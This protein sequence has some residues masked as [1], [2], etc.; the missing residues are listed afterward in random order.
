MKGKG[1]KDFDRI[2]ER[3]LPRVSDKEVESA[4][5]R[6]L[7]M[8]RQ[9]HELQEALDNFRTPGPATLSKYVSLGFVDQL[10]L[11]AVY[12]LRGNGSTLGVVEKVNQ[13]LTNKNFDA[14]A[15]FVSLD[16]LERGRLIA[17][18]IVDE[19]QDKK[20]RVVLKITPEGGRALREVR[21]GLK[22][23]LE[24]LKDIG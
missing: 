11:T 8:L 12:L 14:G 16:R 17:S 13:L 4:R 9:R 18:R 20:K 7:L 6:F 23:L 22:Q 10:V 2:V 19:D 21:D 5:G 15:V 24:A 3:Y 1:S